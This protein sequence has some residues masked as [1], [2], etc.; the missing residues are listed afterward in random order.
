MDTSWHWK[1]NQKSA[2]SVKSSRNPNNIFLQLL[3]QN[4]LSVYVKICAEEELLHGRIFIIFEPFLQDS[5]V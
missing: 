4:L 2:S 1:E 3:L 5:E